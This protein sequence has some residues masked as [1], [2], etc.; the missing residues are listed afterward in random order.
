ML[1]SSTIHF[2]RLF[3]F[4]FTIPVLCYCHAVI[5]MFSFKSEAILFALSFLF[6][7]SALDVS[8]RGDKTIVGKNKYVVAPS[9]IKNI[10]EL[11]EQYGIG[12]DQFMAANPQLTSGKHLQAGE[13]FFIPARS[14]L[15]KAIP[16]NT[17]VIKLWP[18]SAEVP[19]C[20][21][22]CQVKGCISHEVGR[23]PVCRP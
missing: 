4:F 20:R 16:N 23:R 1:L 11:P 17:I 7:H 9:T 21:R 3:L 19:A 5:A 10:D 18:H 2:F 13:I 8:Y 14:I 12:H 6:S 15:P 22:H